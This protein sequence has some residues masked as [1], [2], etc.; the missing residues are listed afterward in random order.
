MEYFSSEDAPLLGDFIRKTIGDPHRFSHLHHEQSNFIVANFPDTPTLL[1]CS[2]DEFSDF[3]ESPASEV[4]PDYKPPAESRDSASQKLAD[5]PTLEYIQH[6]AI[7][8]IIQLL[9]PVPFM[10]PMG[11]NFIK[12]SLKVFLPGFVLGIIGHVLFLP[13]DKSAEFSTLHH[14]LVDP[15]TVFRALFAQVKIGIIGGFLV[16]A[17]MSHVL[18]MCIL[19]HT[20]CRLARG[21]EPQPTAMRRTMDSSRIFQAI[22]GFVLDLIAGIAMLPAGCSLRP[23]YCDRL[24]RSGLV[25]DYRHSIMIGILGTTAVHVY[26]WRTRQREAKLRPLPVDP[27]Q[28]AAKCK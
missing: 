1:D 13:F 6:V 12:R 16:G 24:T 8:L 23:S 7:I 9:I 14:S 28:L 3:V 25:M 5:L 19:I 4:P 11:I 10:L 20:I 2:D 17:V 22:R 15:S 26:I 21:L 18:N 27:A